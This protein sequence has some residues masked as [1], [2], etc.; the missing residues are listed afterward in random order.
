MA[1][2]ITLKLIAS[3][4]LA[5]SLNCTC[6]ARELQQAQKDSAPALTGIVTDR[7]SRS[8]LRVW[9]SILEIVMARDKQGRQ[10]HPTLYGLYHRAETSG[11]LIHIELSEEESLSRAGRFRIETLDPSGTRH[12]M[13]IR[14]NLPTIDRT[15]VGESTRHANGWIPF[16][17]LRTT[18]R[19]AEVLGH[20]L[21]HAISV[22]QDPE[23]LRL[24]QQLEKETKDL[25]IGD[26]NDASGDWP[27]RLESVEQ[28]MR[29][30]ERPAEAAE[31]EIW[32]ELQGGRPLNM[33]ML[34]R[35][36]SGVG[37]EAFAP[38]RSGGNRFPP[39]TLVHASHSFFPVRA[40]W[41]GFMHVPLGR[42][43][44]GCV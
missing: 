12:V 31:L 26:G 15:Y 39:K 23:A 9:R 21:A 22:F 2:H 4:I 27:K 7:L 38:R 25:E 17:G 44:G 35:K 11:H 32:R 19:Y 41:H 8:Q 42:T 28:L 18:Q 37:P 24:Y 3:T 13:A 33:R 29:Q 6:P 40:G 34:T 43:F 20:E 10:L 30:I 36:R 16:A 14:L 1:S 5:L